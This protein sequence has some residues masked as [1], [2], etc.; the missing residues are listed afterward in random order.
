MDHYFYYP[1]QVRLGLIVLYKYPLL[2][3]PLNCTS[4]HTSLILTMDHYLH[5]PNI[6]SISSQTWTYS[7]VQRPITFITPKL[8]IMA[9]IY[10][11][12]QGMATFKSMNAQSKS[13]MKPV[14]VNRQDL[15]DLTEMY[16]FWTAGPISMIQRSM[17]RPWPR[18]KHWAHPEVKAFP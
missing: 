10:N 1:N 16:N 15:W 12:D 6:W 17:E 8:Y 7:Y 5:Y 4:W 13:E 11:F 18:D 2:S 3:L 9:Y 14:F